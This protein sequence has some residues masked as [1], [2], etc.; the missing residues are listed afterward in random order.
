MLPVPPSCAHK[1]F[2]RDFFFSFLASLCHAKAE[3]DLLCHRGLQKEGKHK[4]LPRHPS[5][6]GVWFPAPL[7]TEH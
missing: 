7:S 1:A 2:L 3:A 5:G 4:P 6:A